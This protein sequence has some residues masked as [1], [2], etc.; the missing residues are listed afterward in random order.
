M[1]ASRFDNPVP[2]LTLIVPRSPQ[3]FRTSK[4]QDFSPLNENLLSTLNFSR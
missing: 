4:L 3:N 1:A 2:S